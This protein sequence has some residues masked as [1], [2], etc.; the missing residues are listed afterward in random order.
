MNPRK[1]F[2]LVELL[3]VIAII[4]ILVALLLPAVQAARESA[5]RTQCKNQLKQIGLA[6]QNYHDLNR[7]F[8]AGYYSQFD[9]NGDEL[10]PGWGWGAALLAELE[11]TNLA[12]RI[13]L[14]LG[15]GDAQ[16]AALRTTALPVFLCPSEVHGPQF[17]VAN[18]SVTVA[19]GNYVAINGNGGVSDFAGSND[20][21]FLRN[22][23]FRM[24]DIADGLSNTLFVG[25]RCSHMSF[26]TW[27]GGVTGGEVVSQLDP[28]GIETDAALVLSHAGP[29]V[30]NNPEVTDADATASFHPI[31][32]NFLFGDGSVHV[33]NNTIDVP[34]YDALATRHGGEA[35]SGDDY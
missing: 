16:N 1:G 12:S 29:H 23:W 28:A 8:P 34:I 33:I 24:A 20:G 17:T 26:T 22:R 11:Q 6:M 4:G 5:R 3:V 10:G 2:T 7:A 13:N 9:G 30:P 14:N 27:T 32:V 18:T 35:A 15:I 31:G 21:A 19:Y 25:E